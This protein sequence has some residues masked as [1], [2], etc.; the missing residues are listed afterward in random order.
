VRKVLAII[1]ML[2]LFVPLDIFGNSAV[3]A[4]YKTVRL[5]KDVDSNFWGYE[6][7]DYMIK[8]GA[9]NGYPDGTFRPNAKLKR[10][11]VA[12]MLDR[13][14]SFSALYDDEQ[15]NGVI[16]KDVPKDLD[17][18]KSVAALYMTGHADILFTS[19][20]FEQP[21]RNVTRGEIAYILAKLYSL[22]ATKSYE[23]KDVSKN[24]L[25]YP[26][27]AALIENGVT[28]L[29]EDGSFKPN[30]DLTRA[31]FAMF[32]SRITNP[33]FNEN[34]RDIQGDSIYYW[35]NY[36]VACLSQPEASSRFS[37]YYRSSTSKACT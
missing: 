13:L 34:N 25:F 32:V 14:L 36:W 18:Y 33:Y 4:E 12:K 31:Q 35:G 16:L 28:K 22:E 9:I 6:A 19:D 11:N 30:N 17:G 23:V 20:R 26:A 10:I 3:Y 24:N 27:V 2:T 5:F 21:Y 37:T 8:Q 15:L 29:Y 1:M 7:I